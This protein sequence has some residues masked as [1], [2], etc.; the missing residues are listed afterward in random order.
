MSYHVAIEL[1]DAMVEWLE[2]LV[3]GAESHRK[4]MSRRL[5]FAMLQRENSLYQPNSKWVPFS[6]QGKIRQ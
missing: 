4:V 6:S 5:S 1:R 3:Y 2:R